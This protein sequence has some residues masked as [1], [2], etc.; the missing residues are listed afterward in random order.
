MT[1]TNRQMSSAFA[2]SLKTASIAIGLLGLLTSAAC[3]VGSDDPSNMTDSGGSGNAAAGATGLVV[4]ADFELRPDFDVGTCAKASRIDVNLGN[5]ADSFVTAAYC[6]VN[7]TP[8]PADV[9]A[10]WVSQ[11]TTVSYVRRIDVVLSL[12]KAANLNCSL[13]YSDPWQTQADLSE[14]CMRSG[15]RDVGAVLMFF[16]DCPG[17][18]NCSMDWAN[19]H[20]EGMAAASP[21]S[22]MPFDY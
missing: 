20:A 6:Q 16:N 4:G 19:T 15:T 9:K 1:Y 7:G 10:Q 3:G 21:L 13:N 12:C 18:V 8:P 14:P 17:G 11:L 5:T 2:T 22:L